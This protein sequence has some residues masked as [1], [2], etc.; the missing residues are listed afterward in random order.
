[1]SKWN[2][3]VE[4]ITDDGAW[5]SGITEDGQQ[6]HGLWPIA[7]VPEDCR[8]PGTYC[9]MEGALIVEWC[10]ETWTKEEIEE[11]KRGAYRLRKL[12]GRGK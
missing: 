2:A 12:F 1:M 8:V 7:D 9:K 10:R 11:A 6:W 5:F 3:W 4:E